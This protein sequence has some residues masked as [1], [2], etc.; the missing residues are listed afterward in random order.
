MSSRRGW[1]DCAQARSNPLEKNLPSAIVTR[2]ED[3]EAGSARTRRRAEQMESMRVGFNRC[4]SEP[5]KVRM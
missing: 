1:D 3:G 4:S 5:V 2:A